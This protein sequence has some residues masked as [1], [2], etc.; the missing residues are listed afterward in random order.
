[1]SSTSPLIYREAG[2]TGLPNGGQNGPPHRH[3]GQRRHHVGAV[4][5]HIL[6]CHV[7][8]LEDVLN[9]LLS[10]LLNGAGLLALLHHGHDL[11]LAGA[12]PDGD[13]PVLHIP[14]AHH[15]HIGDLLH[16]GLPDLFCRSSHCGGPPPPG[17]PAGPGALAIWSAYSAARSV[18][19]STFTWTGPARRGKPRR[20]AR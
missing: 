2:Q 16:G 14:V 6:R 11:V 19:G 12:V 8:E 18:T 15:Q 9:Q 4:D 1:M 17:S 20:S 7:V 10:L 13:G 3:P 5:H